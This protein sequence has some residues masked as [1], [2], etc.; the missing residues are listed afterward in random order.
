MV[1]AKDMESTR[2]GGLKAQNEKTTIFA[3]GVSAGDIRQGS[4]GD[5]YL[6]SAMSVI[7]HSRPELLKKIFHPQSRQIRDDGLYTIMMYQGRSPVVLTVD[8]RF[9]C[10][11]RSMRHAF[12]SLFAD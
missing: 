2:D 7:A 4:L 12:V 9:L 3:D 1:R 11:D 8:D 6:L 5:C 10:N